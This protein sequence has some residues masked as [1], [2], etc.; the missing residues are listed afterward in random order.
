[1]DGRGFEDRTDALVFEWRYVRTTVPGKAS[2][3]VGQAVHWLT[4]MMGPRFLSAEWDVE[5]ALSV[6]GWRNCVRWGRMTGERVWELEDLENGEDKGGEDVKTKRGVTEAG[7]HVL[8]GDCPECGGRLKSLGVVPRDRLVV[9][10]DYGGGVFK[11]A[12]LK[13]FYNKP[14]MTEKRREA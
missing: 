12:A 5:L 6:V 10:E 14:K 11:F 9:M 3:G 8:A 13:S 4:Y 1:M 7:R 2:I